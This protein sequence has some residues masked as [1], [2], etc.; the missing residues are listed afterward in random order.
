MSTGKFCR[1]HQSYIIALEKISSTQ[2]KSLTI[3]SLIINI[4]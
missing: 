1:V 4:G 3:G 2:K